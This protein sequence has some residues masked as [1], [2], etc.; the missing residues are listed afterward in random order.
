MAVFDFS[1]AIEINPGEPGIYYNRAL[2]NFFKKD[3]RNALS[4]ANKAKEL[5]YKISP[6]FIEGLREELKSQI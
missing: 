3:Y 1:K 5:G 6:K 2:S 4:D